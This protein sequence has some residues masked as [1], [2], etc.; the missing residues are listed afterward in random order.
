M[1]KLSKFTYFIIVKVSVPGREVL[2][3]GINLAFFI[4]PLFVFGFP[5]LVLLEVSTVIS[6]PT[7]DEMLL[8]CRFQYGKSLNLLFNASKLRLKSVFFTQRFP[9]D[10]RNPFGYSLAVLLQLEILNFLLH[11]ICTFFSLGFAGLLFEFSFVKDLKGDLNKFNNIAKR[12]KSQAHCTKHLTEFICF[13]MDAKELSLSK[14][15]AEIIVFP[16]TIR[17]FCTDYPATWRKC[18]LQH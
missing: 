3:E 9:F 1:E 18:F 5:G 10:S 4:L 15:K 2:C 8:N 16:K 12:K 14:F 11:Y 7:W 6:P 13:Y 17:Q